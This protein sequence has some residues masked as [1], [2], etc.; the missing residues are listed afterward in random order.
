MKKFLKKIITILIII[1]L[2]CLIQKLGIL[3]FS[4][5]GINE[6]KLN[7]Y[8]GYYYKQLDKEEKKIYIKLDEAI[9]KR[10]EKVFLGVNQIDD[11]SKKISKVLT[12]Y[13]YDNPTCYYVSNRYMIST[14]DIKI[15][16]YAI[17][18]LDYIISNEDELNIKNN[19]FKQA[20]QKILKDN[21]T[22]EMSDFEKEVALHDAL[23]KHVDYYQYEDLN[24]MPAIKHTAYAAL[25]EKQ[26]VCDGYSKAFMI[27]LKEAGIESI[28]VNGEAENV[29]HAWNMVK[30][31]DEYYHVDVTSDKV[32][33]N[34]KKYAVHTYFNLS[35]EEILHTHTLDNELKK[36]KCTATKYNYYNQL[37]YIVRNNERLDVKLKE[38]V[39]KQ[40]NSSILELKAENKHSAKK[41]VD[42]LYELNFD[43][44]RSFGKTSITYNT[45]DDTYVFI[46]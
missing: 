19:E 14:S 45:I 12:A 30:I 42:M 2:I 5:F 39:K 33:E 41:I 32:R 7:S 22:E 16:K 15:C 44:W 29:S 35:D 21:I 11:L 1:F 40:K 36:P 28:I 20:I 27:L 3:D 8:E 13:F 10:E 31:E 37:N 24:K 4:A 23:V 46:K 26:A 9:E 34:S 6:E 25:V 38:I 17:I 18:E 43:N